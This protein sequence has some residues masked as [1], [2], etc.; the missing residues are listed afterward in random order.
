MKNWWMPGMRMLAALHCSRCAREFYGDLPAGHGLYYPMLLDAGTGEVHDAQAVP[1]FAESL[2]E[3]FARR[4]NQPV[5]FQEERFRPLQKPVL[6]NC[7][8]Q[9]YGHS[10]LKLLNAQYYLEH[11]PDAE[12]ILLLPRF[13]RWLAPAGAAA[14]WTVDLPL[15]QGNVWND[16]LA[17]R[18]HELIDPLPEAWLSLAFS[19]PHPEDFAIERFTRVT[20]FDAAAWGELLRERPTVT[21]IW[22]E[23]RLWE[24]ARSRVRSK[25][26]RWG[27]KAERTLLGASSAAAVE[28]R[29]QQ[30]LVTQLALRLR[31]SL[32]RLDFAV[33]GLGQRGGLPEWIGDLRQPKIDESVERAWCQRYASSHLVVGVHGFEHALAFGAR[34]GGAG[35]VAPRSL[36][37]SAP[38]DSAADEGSAGCLGSDSVPAAG[39][40]RRKRR[41]GCRRAPAGCAAD[42]LEFQPPVV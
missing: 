22:R 17:R 27:N 28:V 2:R 12:L 30:R 41:G 37:E 3:S 8:D 16:W 38:G 15:R 7:L 23:D 9:L 36:G 14:I 13:L 35:T 6:L 31:Q 19:H 24:G 39:Q 42:R 25:L 11:R 29:A 1:W 20:P 26:R 21:F 33:A 5:P 10:L 18:L 4:I 34:R 32:P 40:R